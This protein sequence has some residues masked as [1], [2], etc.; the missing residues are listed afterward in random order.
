MAKDGKLDVLSKDTR[1]LLWKIIRIL[2][3]KYC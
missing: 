1:S 2:D 3:T